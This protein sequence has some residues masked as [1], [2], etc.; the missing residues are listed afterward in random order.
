MSF[1]VVDYPDTLETR[2]ELRGAEAKNG[3]NCL[4]FIVKIF[5]VAVHVAHD[6]RRDFTFLRNKNVL[7]FTHFSAWTPDLSDDLHGSYEA[8]CKRTV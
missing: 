7:N 1:I 6:N 4:E 5:G 3:K 2:N 8:T